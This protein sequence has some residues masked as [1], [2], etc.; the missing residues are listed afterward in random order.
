M[1]FGRIRPGVE[2]PESDHAQEMQ[3]SFQDSTPLPSWSPAVFHRWF[4][5]KQK[6]N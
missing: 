1:T 5:C 6:F 4:V 2:E 3:T